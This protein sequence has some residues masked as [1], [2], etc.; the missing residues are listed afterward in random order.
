MGRP[1]TIRVEVDCAGQ[2]TRI[3][4]SDD[5]VEIPKEDVPNVFTRFYR[6]DKSRTGQQRG[7]GLGLA[8]AKCIVEAHHGRITLK[9]GEGK[10]V[11]Y[12]ILI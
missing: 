10:G 6:V 9:S 7:S 4:F 11:V 1:G 8:I 12:T 3:I 2:H 5:G